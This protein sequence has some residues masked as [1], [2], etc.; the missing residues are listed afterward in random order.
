MFY[1]YDFPCPLFLNETS[2]WDVAT[3]AIATVDPVF[4]CSSH[5]SGVLHAV[6]VRE[7]QH[8]SY[9]KHIHIVNPKDLQDE[10]TL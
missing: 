4:V 8:I 1:G 6:T 9:T 7:W 3:A 5:Y 2:T 10:K